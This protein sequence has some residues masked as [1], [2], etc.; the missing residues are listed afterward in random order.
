MLS[1]IASAP[2]VLHYELYPIATEEFAGPG[3]HILSPRIDD[4]DASVHPS[5]LSHSVHQKITDLIFH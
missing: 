3:T 1:E 4:I 5:W 2:L